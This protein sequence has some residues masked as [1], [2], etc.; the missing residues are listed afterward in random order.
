MSRQIE[1]TWR[2]R[3]VPLAPLAVAA[4]GEVA[5]R[6]AQRLLALDDETLA[7]LQGVVGEGLLIVLGEA[8]ALPWVDGVIYLGRDPLAPALLLPTTI[9]TEVP[10]ALFERALIERWQDHPPFALLIDPPMIASVTSARPIARQPL[11]AWLSQDTKEATR[12]EVTP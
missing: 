9:V 5:S 8:V 4:R 10:L 11:A 7:T 2:L 12:A 1:I 3:D 6:L